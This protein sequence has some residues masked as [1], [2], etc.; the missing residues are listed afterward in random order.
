MKNLLTTLL[1]VAS[2]GM[3]AQTK[4]LKE[5]LWDRVE[6]CNSAL[7]DMDEDGAIDYEVKIDDAKNGYLKIGGSYPTCGCACSHEVGA[8]KTAVGEYVLID[9]STWSCGWTHKISSNRDLTSVLPKGLEGEV[10]SDNPKK[11]YDLAY[12][13]FDLDIPQHGTETKLYVKIIPIGLAMTPRGLPFSY[14]YEESGHVN[15][16]AIYQIPE[17]LKKFDYVVIQ[18]LMN[19]EYDQLSEKDRDIL[20][21][22]IKKNDYDSS[23]FATLEEI[24]EV[25]NHL[26]DVYEE[27]QNLKYTSLTMDWDRKLE[28][29][30]IKSKD[31]SPEKMSFEKFLEEVPFWMPMC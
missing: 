21:S 5:L 15:N 19:G 11:G 2:I 3:F 6:P 30:Y 8:F 25:L 17:I 16:Y 26:E 29:F 12:F 14:Y 28:R 31:A 13:Y 9:K 24:T 1:L 27:Y 23:R 10:M 7:E 4:S 18:H 20:D 22:Y